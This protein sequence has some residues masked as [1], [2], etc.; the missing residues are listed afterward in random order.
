MALNP[1]LVPCLPPEAAAGTKSPVEAFIVKGIPGHF[2][3]KYK[4]K[5]HTVKRAIL[6]QDNSD[7]YSN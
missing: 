3:E 2:G 4:K 7:S 5:G 6:E 1:T